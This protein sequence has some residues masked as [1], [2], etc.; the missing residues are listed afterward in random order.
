MQP[1]I[2]ALIPAAGQS[3]RMG[4]CKLLLPLPDQAGREQPVIGRCLETLQQAGIHDIVLVLGEPY[5]PDIR[6]AA[7]PYGA[8]VAWN[9]EPASDMAASLRCGLPLLP[10][11]AS[12][13]LVFVPDY[14]LVQPAT[15]RLLLE[16]HRQMPDAILIPTLEG[17]KGHPILLPVAILA[18]LPHHP[19]LRDVIRAHHHQIRYLSTFDQ[20]TI[21]DLD[22]PQDYGHVLATANTP[23]TR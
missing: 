9:P 4:C 12:G 18:Q 17:R 21:N 8:T 22:T 16:R 7:A 2:A 3:R 14:P 1:T 19:T 15:V 11:D 20:G 6:D 23:G 13:I 5:G 10:P